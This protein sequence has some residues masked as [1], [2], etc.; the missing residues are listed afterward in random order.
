VEPEAIAHGEAARALNEQRTELESVRGRAGALVA[1]AAIVTSLFAGLAVKPEDGLQGLQWVALGLFCLVAV[2]CLPQVPWK[3]WWWIPP[4]RD[5]VR[6]YVDEENR[7]DA[8]TMQ[9][10]LALH[11]GENLANNQKPVNKLYYLLAP[12]ARRA[13]LITLREVFVVDVSSDWKRLRPG[14]SCYGL[15]PMRCRPSPVPIFGRSSGCSRRCE[16]VV[17]TT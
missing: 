10:D 13:D 5:L 17:P 12:V 8:R 11:L 2:C 14:P 15:C 9:R 16:T 6:D 7:L 4:A 1:A 3:A